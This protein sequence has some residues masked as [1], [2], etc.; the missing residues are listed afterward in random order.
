MTPRET[1][2]TYALQRN[3]TC[4]QTIVARMCACLLRSAHLA[5]TQHTKRTR[6]DRLHQLLHLDL[7]GRL[8]EEVELGVEADGP[9]VEQ[10]DVIRVLKAR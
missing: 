7:V 1:Y 9:L 4:G 3:L 2:L 5:N 10:G 6:H 8:V